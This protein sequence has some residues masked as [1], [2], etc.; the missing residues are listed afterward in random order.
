MNPPPRA[1]YAGPV[2]GFAELVAAWGEVG[3]D[4]VIVPDA[5]LGSG[6]RRLEAMDAIAAAVAP[7]R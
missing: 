4:E 6:A 5:A 3:V 1:A 7:P 2:A